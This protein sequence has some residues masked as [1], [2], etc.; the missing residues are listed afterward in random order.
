MEIKW[1][2]WEET[3]LILKEQKPRAISKGM[4]RP[5]WISETQQMPTTRLHNNNQQLA[6]LALDFCKPVGAAILKY[7]EL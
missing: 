6:A 2:P 4:W 5:S 1:S 3:S 7:K